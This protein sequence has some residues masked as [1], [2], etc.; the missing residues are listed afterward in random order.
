M[1]L[2]HEDAISHFITNIDMAIF[3]SDLISSDF[4]INKTGTFLLSLFLNHFGKPI[5]ILAE[6][7]KIEIEKT[8]FNETAKNP[9]E[10][11]E[12]PQGI[13]VHNYY[14]EKIPLWPVSKVFTE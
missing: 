7:R 11:M 4:F 2:F 12:S 3:G 1:H 9:A 10:I 14:F 13:Q 5:Y 6:K 8:T